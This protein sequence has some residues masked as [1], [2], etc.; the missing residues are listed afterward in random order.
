MMNPSRSWRPLA[1][2]SSMGRSRTCAMLPAEGFVPR[3]LWVVFECDEA[4][5]IPDPLQCSKPSSEITP[6][7]GRAGAIHLVGTVI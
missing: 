4:P 1:G 7:Y 3:D 5:P 2:R 6:A